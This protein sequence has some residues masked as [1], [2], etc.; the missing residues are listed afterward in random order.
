MPFIF[1]RRKTVSCFAGRWGLSNR[2]LAMGCALS[3]AAELDYRLVVYWDA[4]SMVGKTSF[5]DLFETTAL[6][7][8]LVEGYEA[9]V[10][11]SAVQHGYSKGFK[12]P[13]REIWRLLSS[14]LLSQYDKKF[15]LTPFNDSLDASPQNYRKILISAN[16]LF[17]YDYDMTWL[18]PLPHITARIVE[19]KNKFT[20][21]TV[22]VH[23]RGTD[24][25]YIPPVEEMILRMRAEVELDPGVKF[26]FASD[27]DKHGKAIKDLFGDRLITNTIPDR[28]KTVGGQGGAIVDIF[29]LASTSRIMGPRY[30]TFSFLASILGNKPLL[31]IKRRNK[32]PAS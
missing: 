16:Y 23:M 1:P 21:N 9:R 25:N 13:K 30:S 12:S 28:R 8:E 10:M 11:V 24:W 14:L 32:S 7:F 29:G 17:K 22:G 3:L 20:P 6:P 26:F 27:G 4:D 31:R 18:K 15:Y 5:N 2:I 19:L